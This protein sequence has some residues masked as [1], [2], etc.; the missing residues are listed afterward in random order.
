MKLPFGFEITRRK[1]VAQICC[2]SEPVPVGEIPGLFYRKSE[3]DIVFTFRKPSQSLSILWPEP[4]DSMNSEL[5]KL[6]LSGLVLKIEKMLNG[7]HFDVCPVTSAVS[8]FEIQMSE[9]SYVALEILRSIHCIDYHKLPKGLRQR[10]PDLL[11]CVFSGGAYPLAKTNSEADG[12]DETVEPTAEENEVSL[13][14][15]SLKLTT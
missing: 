15:A 2:E 6:A 7:S 10:L 5:A 14:E 1:K 11:S 4:S 9:D 13:H 8:D 3:S 12:A